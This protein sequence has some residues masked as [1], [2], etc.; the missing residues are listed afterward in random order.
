MLSHFHTL[1]ER[2]R[3]TDGIAISKLRVSV[4]TC[5]KI[6]RFYG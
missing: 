1:T 4:L 5:D 3:G 6:Q 2:D